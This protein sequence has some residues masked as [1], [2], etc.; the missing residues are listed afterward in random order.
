MSNITVALLFII[1]ALWIYSVFS[2]MLN[3]FKNEKEK[4]FWLIGI[5]FLPFLSIFYLIRKKDLLK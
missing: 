5:V 3:E 2:I 1:I 4:V